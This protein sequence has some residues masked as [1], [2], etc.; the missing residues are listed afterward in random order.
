MTTNRSVGFQRANG[1]GGRAR[2]RRTVAVTEL[3]LT[4]ALAASTAIAA[5]AVSVE[6]AH[7]TPL[8]QTVHHATPTIV[9]AGSPLFVTHDCER[10]ARD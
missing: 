4:L 3:F 9:L 7:A 8:K 2:Q 6:M 10:R 5:T 1:N